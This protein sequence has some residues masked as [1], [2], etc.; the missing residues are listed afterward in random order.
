[1]GGVK[2]S[3]E[4]ANFFIN[5]E[6]ATWHDVIALRDIVKRRVLEKEGIELEEEVRIIPPT[7]V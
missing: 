5:D 4:H 3:P 2:V 7:I 1:V 6:K